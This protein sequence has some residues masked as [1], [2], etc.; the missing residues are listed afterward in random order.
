MQV[1]YQLRHSPGL[2]RLRFT[3]SKQPVQL[4]ALSPLTPIGLVSTGGPIGFRVWPG[5]I[6]KKIRRNRSDSGGLSGGA[7]GTR[8]PDP[9]HA[10]QVR[11]QLRHSPE[12]L[13][14]LQAFSAFPEAT[15]IS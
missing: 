15:Q 1:R 12:L 11:Y 3:T 8:T 6:H 13:L 5:G 4:N 14:L 2:C 9:L 7:E 10:M